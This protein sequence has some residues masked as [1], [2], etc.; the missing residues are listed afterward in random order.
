MKIF[1][2]VSNGI[3]VGEASQFMDI[4][5]LC[6]LYDPAGFNIEL[7]Q[8]TFESNFDKEKIQSMINKNKY[9]LGSNE[10]T[11]SQITLRVCDIEQSLFFYQ[12][13]M[14][15]TYLSR[16]AVDIYGFKIY[17]L[18]Y[19]MNENETEMMPKP[20]DLDAVENR[21]WLWQRP[22]TTLE[23]Q[24]RW[25]TPVSK[26]MLAK[27]DETGWQGIVFQSKLNVMETKKYLKQFDIAVEWKDTYLLKCDDPDGYPLLI[28]CAKN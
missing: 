10:V 16:Q 21:E 3:E 17:F 24:H 14:G 25:K 2:Q 12:Q 20:N 11:M 1:Q 7:L 22:Y 9:K 13:I 27:D 6:H 5:Y 26:Y 15:M 28:E 8:H 18:G 23:L 4:G 19:P